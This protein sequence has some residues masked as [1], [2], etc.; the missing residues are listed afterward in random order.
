MQRV[1]PHA[2]VQLGDAGHAAALQSRRHAECVVV[3]HVDPTIGLHR[4]IQHRIDVP[5][6]RHVGGHRER[7]AAGS[8]DLR[9]DRGGVVAVH[10]RH[11]HLAPAL[12][13]AD[14]G[15]AADAGTGPGHHADLAI[16]AHHAAPCPARTSCTTSNPSNSGWPR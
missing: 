13:E 10:V 1:V 7:R 11:H 2:L 5:R 4:A 12:R 9:H 6:L 16:E 15:G 3:Q 8:S 14:R